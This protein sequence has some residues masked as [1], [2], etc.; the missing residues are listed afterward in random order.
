MI[1]YFYF[2]NWTNSLRVQ[3]HSL[4]VWDLILNSTVPSWLELCMFSL[5][6]LSIFFPLQL[7]RF[8]PPPK[9]FLAGALTTPV[10]CDGL[11]SHPGYLPAVYPAFLG[12]TVT[13]IKWCS[14]MQLWWAE[15]RCR[16]NG[17][18]ENKCS[19]EGEVREKEVRSPRSWLR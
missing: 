10:P 17:W 1:L 5:P 15:H 2:F 19:W 3:A 12:S 7:F 8:P 14:D 9:D 4:R 13:L 16:P 18:G 11:A 6:V